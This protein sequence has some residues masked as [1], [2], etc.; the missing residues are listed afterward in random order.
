MRSRTPVLTVSITVLRMLV[1]EI[2]GPRNSRNVASMYAGLAPLRDAAGRVDLRLDLSNLTFVAPC[3]IAALAVALHD[4]ARG[5][6]VHGTIVQPRDPN[7][8]RYLHVMDFYAVLGM[9]PTGQW[10]RPDRHGYMPAVRVSRDDPHAVPRAAR[11]LT[12]AVVDGCE[13]T[14]KAARTLQNSIEELIDNTQQH[15]QS[16]VDAVAVAAS[17]RTRRRIELAVA[18]AGIGIPASVGLNP[19][20]ADRP[21]RHRMR[22]AVE[23]WVSGTTDPNRGN[24]LWQVRELLQ[25]N[26]GTLVL[27]SGGIRLT[28]DEN[29]VNLSDV[30]PI[31]GTLAIMQFNMDIPVGLVDLLAAQTQEPVDDF[32]EVDTWGGG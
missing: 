26:E 2:A 3:A 27:Q 5:C 16:P 29:G 18:D 31:L 32:I 24:G 30:R 22:A 1:I 23:R 20:F 14:D 19:L 4:A 17:W 28:A 9:E 12:D 25:R 10:S 21:E 6:D 8:K 7:V 11:G 15:S 13:L